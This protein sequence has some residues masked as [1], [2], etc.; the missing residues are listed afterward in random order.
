VQACRRGGHVHIHVH[1]S[2]TDLATAHPI[3]FAGVLRRASRYVLAFDWRDWPCWVLVWVV[4]Q[5][6][7]GGSVE[8]CRYPEW[9]SGII[10]LDRE[11]GKGAAQRGTSVRVLGSLGANAV[12]I[13]TFL[14]RYLGTYLTWPTIHA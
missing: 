13:P 4:I 2:F 14:G 9:G 10:I 6:K 7:P 8:G 3:Q 5:A 11:G 1:V 12:A